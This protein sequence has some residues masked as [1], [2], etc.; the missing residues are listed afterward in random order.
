MGV[1]R[2]EP[3]PPGPAA[4]GQE[5][6]VLASIVANL[7]IPAAELEA[8]NSMA[9]PP[10]APEITPA[11]PPVEEAPKP[12][13]AR[14][15]P[16]R[17]AEAA[18]LAVKPEKDDKVAT[19]KAGKAAAAKADSAKPDKSGKTGKT[20]DAKTKPVAKPDPERVWVQV[21]GGA[22]AGDLTK[23][24]KAV[25]AK[26][27]AQFKGKSGWWTPVRASNRLLA[28]PFKT[29]AE[30]QAFVNTLAKAGVSGFVFTSE[31]GQKVSKIGEK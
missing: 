6:S 7:T 10:P 28:G 8:A 19:G 12:A 20:A 9:L 31:A 30:G 3:A 24:W 2:S 22:N 14:P 25:S 18:K 17:R 23:A 26:A 11:P 5:D 1:A 15:A 29:S 13:P 4:V 21:A 16:I 27:P